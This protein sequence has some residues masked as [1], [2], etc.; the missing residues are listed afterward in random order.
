MKMLKWSARS[1][2][3]HSGELE[4]PTQQGKQKRSRSLL[5]LQESPG[6]VGLLQT[7]PQRRKE[8]EEKRLRKKLKHLLRLR[9]SAGLREYAKTRLSL[10]F[11]SSLDDDTIIESIIVEYLTSE[12]TRTF[13]K[14]L[15]TERQKELKEDLDKIRFTLTGAFGRQTLAGVV[16]SR[17]YQEFLEEDCTRFVQDVVSAHWH[18][19]LRIQQLFEQIPYRLYPD[20]LKKIAEFT[21]VPATRVKYMRIFYRA[22]P[23]GKLLTSNLT[24][25]RIANILSLLYNPV[26]RAWIFQH[27]KKLAKMDKETWARWLD[28]QYGAK[29]SHRN[30]VPNRYAVDLFP[31]E[32]ATLARLVQA[33]RKAKEL[34]QILEDLGKKNEIEYLSDVEEFT[35]LRRLLGAEETDTTTS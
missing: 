6:E 15:L 7:M 9:G 27:S 1:Q 26:V 11:S 34:R 14:I 4:E 18:L 28:N 21:H 8:R 20:L 3:S 19:G 35:T 2:P 5:S 32:R 12:E 23:E 13:E 24:W 33:R 31:E 17:R 16:N 25:D 10:D 29:R 22:D 30:R